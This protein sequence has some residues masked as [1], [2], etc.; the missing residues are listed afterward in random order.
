MDLL[1]KLTIILTGTQKAFN[2]IQH[3]FM[4]K[5]EVT[6]L[7][8]G[9]YLNMIKALSDKY[10]VNFIINFRKTQSNLIKIRT[11]EISNNLTPVQ[12]SAGSTS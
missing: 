2:K 3:T 12:Y 6:V 4:V 9:T 11:K 8:E 10:S 5:V 1:A 7:L